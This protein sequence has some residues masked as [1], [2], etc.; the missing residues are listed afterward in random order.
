MWLTLLRDGHHDALASR[1]CRS[2][3]QLAKHFDTKQNQF[4]LSRILSAA[5]MHHLTWVASVA[6]P[7]DGA[8]SSHDTR[9]VP[10]SFLLTNTERLQSVV[11][12]EYDAVWAQYLE[13]TGAVGN[14][15][16][17]ARVVVIGDDANRIMQLLFVLS[18]FLRSSSVEA[19]EGER[20][21]ER[22]A[23]ACRRHGRVLH[24]R[25]LL[26]FVLLVRVRRGFTRFRVAINL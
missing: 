1:F 17:Q 5:L 25:G 11:G 6:S 7:Q 9:Q 12:N 14:A 8:S 21:E 3:S 18:Y 16:R 19:V 15:V 10:S 24:H 22:R 23:L 4:F 20:G 13:V 26:G 2:F